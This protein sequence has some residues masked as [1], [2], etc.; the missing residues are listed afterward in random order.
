MGFGVV[1]CTCLKGIMVVIWVFVCFFYLFGLSL[2]FSRWFLG[3]EV[4]FCAF[5][6][7]NLGIFKPFR[8]FFGFLSPPVLVL[9]GS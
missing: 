8:F 4:F 7:S 5:G 6:L 9:L 1:L 2:Y 3:S